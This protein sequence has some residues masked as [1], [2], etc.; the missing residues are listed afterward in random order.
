MANPVFLT[1]DVINERFETYVIT[2]ATA[3]GN[4]VKVNGE[5]VTTFA[6]LLGKCKTGRAVLYGPATTAETGYA[7]YNAASV[8]STLIQFQ[9]SGLLYAP[10]DARYG[11]YVHRIRITPSGADGFAIADSGLVGPYA[12]AISVA[13]LFDSAKTYAVDEMVM[14]G[15][16]LYRC[17]TAVTTAG[18]WN[19]ANW[20][21][22]TATHGDTAFLK[23]AQGH[24]VIRETEGQGGAQPQTLYVDAYRLAQDTATH[25][26]KD[27]AIN[28]IGE[29]ADGVTLA[30][31]PA[32][33]GHSR[34]FAVELKIGATVPAF[35]FPLVEA[36][37]K[38][39]SDPI[40]TWAANTV[41]C[42]SFTEFPDGKWRL[43]VA[44]KTEEVTA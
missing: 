28:E 12:D 9:V 27:A 42:I 32:V 10:G 36:N 7:F 2:E 22:D 18:A 17:T 23:D 29:M 41:Y 43:G 30:L 1:E 15:G 40:P 26:I 13:P 8:T 39:Y 16:N 44:S 14:H 33:A 34:D 19:A 35:V 38:P 37:L 20:T 4:S 25:V 31:P 11:N 21:Q 5:T 6:D 3:G 24:L